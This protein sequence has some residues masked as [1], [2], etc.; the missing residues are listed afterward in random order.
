VCLGYV[1]WNDFEMSKEI[2]KTDGFLTSFPQMTPID[3]SKNP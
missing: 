1:P 3:E 2:L